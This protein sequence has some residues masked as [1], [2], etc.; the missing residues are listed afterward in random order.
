VPLYDD[1]KPRLKAHLEAIHRGERVPVIA[2]GLLTE[3]QFQEIREIQAD[4]GL[5]LLEEREILYLGKHNYNSRSK[6]GYS[7]DDMILQIESALSED[8]IVNGHRGTTLENPHPRIDGY[9]N[10]VN[11][12]AVLEMTQRKPKSELYSV[13]PKGDSNKPS[14]A[15]AV[16]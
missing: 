2:I 7:I 16:A 12:R 1:A 15:A 6:E 13:M 8:S 4:K 3:R 14:D 10:T 5:A 11:D 9:G